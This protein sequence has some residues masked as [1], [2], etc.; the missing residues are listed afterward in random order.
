VILISLFV[1]PFVLPAATVIVLTLLVWYLTELVA[2]VPLALV[3]R[4]QTG[5]PEPPK[6]VNMP[7]LTFRL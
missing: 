6:R 5:T 4:T 7:E 2:W 1:A 3:H